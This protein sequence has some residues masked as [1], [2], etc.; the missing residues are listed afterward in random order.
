MEFCNDAIDKLKVEGL[1]LKDWDAPYA[2]DRTFYWVKIKRFYD[3]DARIVGFYNGR[4]KTRLEH[5]IAGVNCIGFLED[6]TRVEFRVGSGFSD[7]QRADML[8]NPQKWLD[9]THVFKYQEISRAK[10]K[11]YASLRFPTYER[12][13]EDKL[14]EI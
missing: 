3:I 7:A 11:E 5:T 12:S 14:V 6:N 4:P 8:A 2:W 1:I 13:R 10:N 9:G